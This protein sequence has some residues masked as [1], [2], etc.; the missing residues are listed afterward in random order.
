MNDAP[1]YKRI[2]KE[3][4]YWEQK[5]APK[6]AAEALQLLD[7]IAHAESP[8]WAIYALEQYIKKADDRS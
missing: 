6:D 5:E 8:E 7:L 4:E 2:R 1:G 3:K